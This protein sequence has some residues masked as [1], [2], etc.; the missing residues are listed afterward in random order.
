MYGWGTYLK[1]SGLTYM[2]KEE[3]HPEDVEEEWVVEERYNP[4]ILPRHLWAHQK[5]EAWLLA[6]ESMV[7]REIEAYLAKHR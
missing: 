2:N 7:D 5:T 4:P 6:W 3:T 1:V